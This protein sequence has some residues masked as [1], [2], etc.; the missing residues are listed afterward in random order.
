MA[1]VP[2]F[3]V[4]VSFRQ[5]STA[6]AAPSALSSAKSA[7]FGCA[8]SLCPCTPSA[9]SRAA[10]GRP[11]VVTPRAELDSDTLVGHRRGAGRACR[12]HWH[13]RLLRGPPSRDRKSARTTSRASPAKAPALCR[14]GSARARAWWVE[15]GGGEREESECINCSGKG[16]ITCTTCQGA[17]VQPRYLDRR[18][19]K[20]DD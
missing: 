14:A 16:A 9:A 8:S 1:A 11:A 7:S 15:L 3:R 13:S 17:G 5:P 4:A 12:G 10:K 2:V 18:E 20:D 6:A 19:F